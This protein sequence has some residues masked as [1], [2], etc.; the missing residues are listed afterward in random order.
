MCAVASVVMMLAACAPVPSIPRDPAPLIGNGYPEN[1]RLQ[2]PG[3][4]EVVVVINDNV[5]MVHAGMFV[6]QKLFDPAGSYLG[7]RGLDSQWQGT[8]LGDYVR[9]QLEDGPL[10]KLYRF[11]LEP[12]AF[13]QIKIRV[14]EAGI[15]VPLFCAARVQNVVSG[16]T[17]FAAVPDAWFVSPSSLAY[18]L[19]LVVGGKKPSGA[20]YWPDGSSCNPRGTQEVL[21]AR[22]D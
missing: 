9:F 3:A 22:R 18:H 11:T 2:E 19:D 16:V 1:L 12:E 6:A 8:S 4:N 5:Q 17:P 13:A 15:T 20:C 10:V 14:E 7:T 21:E